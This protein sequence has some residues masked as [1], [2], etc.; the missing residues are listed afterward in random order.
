MPLLGTTRVSLIHRLG[1]GGTDP[2]AWAEFV[3]TYGA[4][5]IE[6]CRRYGLQDS[7]AQDVAQ[8]VLVRF[9]RQA[10]RFRYD[11][12]RRLRGYLRRM[13]TTAVSDWAEKR[14]LDRQATGDDAIQELIRDVP[15]RD[16]LARR[17]EDLFDHEVLAMAMREVEERVLPHTWRAFRLLAID[18]VPGEEVA[19]L[20]G[21]ELNHA[22]RAR[23]RVQCMIRE[24]V[25]RIEN[26]SIGVDPG[27]RPSPK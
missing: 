5:V 10:E 27:R 14:R 25:E 12:R 18:G 4:A 16:E 19:G 17:I 2:C 21:I 7:D 24:A 23:S 9:W 26:R 11:P 1:A 8:E 22:Y 13:V 6:W 3:A 20:L 15:A